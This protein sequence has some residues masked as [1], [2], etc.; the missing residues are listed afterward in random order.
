MHLMMRERERGYE[1]KKWNKLVCYD[2]RSSP[3]VISS[4]IV[5]SK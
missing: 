4:F 1:F 5:S 3:S 2:L